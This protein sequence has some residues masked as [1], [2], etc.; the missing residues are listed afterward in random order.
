M[1]DVLLKQLILENLGNG[2]GKA[3]LVESGQGPC[4]T[5]GLLEEDLILRNIM[6]CGPG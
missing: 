5:G 1:E 6:L 3:G 4:E 2:R